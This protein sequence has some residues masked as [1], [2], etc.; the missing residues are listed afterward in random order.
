MM[1]DWSKM[2]V[3][4]HP[5]PLSHTHAQV[6]AGDH[7][8]HAVKERRK[9]I[10]MCAEGGATM[11]AGVE[12]CHRHG[13]QLEE[14]NGMLAGMPNAADMDMV[15]LVLPPPLLCLL[16]PL[17]AAHNTIGLGNTRCK[18]SLLPQVLAQVWLPSQH[19]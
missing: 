2:T 9:L 6:V 1:V 5:P 14:M 18:A 19:L 11:R 13:V 12:G 16:A 4:P 17:T 10:E 8:D 3:Q 15:R 7:T